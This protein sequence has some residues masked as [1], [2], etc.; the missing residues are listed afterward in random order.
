MSI[1]VN[2][3]DDRPEFAQPVPM[4]RLPFSFPMMCACALSVLALSSC[5]TDP[6]ASD[7][8]GTSY[9]SAPDG[10]AE[11]VIAGISYWYY[12]DHYCRYWPG[13][14]YVVVPPPYGRPPYTRPPVVGPGR[15]HKPAP[16]YPGYRRSQPSIQPVTGPTTRPVTN[17]GW[18]G[19]SPGYSGGG[20]GGGMGGGMGGGGMRGGGRGGGRR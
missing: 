8:E 13:Y 5:A 16:S 12:D 2:P 17:P 14:G 11:T 9:S 18:Q 7:P 19:G 4:R 6:Y 1:S 3:D 15:P 20:F 10:Y